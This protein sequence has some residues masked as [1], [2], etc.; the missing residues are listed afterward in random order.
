MPLASLTETTVELV[1]I[2]I[3][4]V[5]LTPTVQLCVS[6]FF[7]GVIKFGLWRIVTINSRWTKGN[8][9]KGE[10]ELRK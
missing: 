5:N 6:C 7:G 8:Q 9:P 1:F 10:G 3:Y 2:F 4:I